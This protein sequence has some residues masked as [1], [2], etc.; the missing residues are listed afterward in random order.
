MAGVWGAPVRCVSRC[1]SDPR[2]S[3]ST[4][5]S[6][7][8]GARACITSADL[9]RSDDWRVADIEHSKR[10]SGWHDRDFHSERHRRP[11]SVSVSL[12]GAERRGNVAAASGMDCHAFFGLDSDTPWQLR[13][14]DLGAKRRL[15][16]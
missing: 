13:H 10:A 7:T 15:D 1:E 6:T 9:E 4:A 11:R 8:A 14:C 2:A 5:A 16:Q 12:V 3:P